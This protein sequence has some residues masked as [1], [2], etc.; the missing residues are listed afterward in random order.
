[1]PLKY[2]KFKKD[3]KMKKAI[4]SAAV[5]L[6]LGGCSYLSMEKGTNISQATMEQIVVNKSTQSDVERIIGY[7]QN[8]QKLGGGEI[9]YYEFSKVGYLGNK[10]EKTV[11]E[12]DKKGVVVKKYKTGGNSK[13]P[14]TGK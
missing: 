10:D 5:L 12:F 4:L 8:K 13:N 14:L 7:P 6:A 9:W 1:M 3:K 2:T 11:F